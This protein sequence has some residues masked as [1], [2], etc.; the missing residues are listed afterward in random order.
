MTRAGFQQLAA[1]R[2]ADAAALLAASRWSGAYYLAGYAV[3]CGL[4][5]C[6]MKRVGAEEG[7]MLFEDRRF[8]QTSCLT[9]DLEALLRGALLWDLFQA[10]CHSG[11]GLDRHWRTVK[12]WSEASRYDTL[13]LIEARAMCE[14]VSDPADG[15]LPWIQRFW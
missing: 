2:A 1:T 9:H 12:K 11:A 15:L 3:E 7:G 5:A 13:S 14:A 10:D 8:Q 6:V 4:K